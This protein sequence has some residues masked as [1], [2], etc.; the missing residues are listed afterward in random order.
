MLKIQV[1]VP[2]GFT[3]AKLQ[4]AAGQVEHA[5]AKFRLARIHQ[6]V[7]ESGERNGGFDRGPGR[8]GAAQRSIQQ[9]LVDVVLQEAELRYRQ[10]ARE[11]VGIEGGRAGQ[12]QHVA[13]ARIDGHHGASL[14]D[15]PFLGDAL[16]AHV[17]AQNQIAA[18][19]R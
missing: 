3:F 5:G 1:A 17:D 2:A 15:Q 11:S 12:R 19:H 6:V 13:A 9:G 10:A 14:A 18:R 7:G 16:H 8:V 4:P